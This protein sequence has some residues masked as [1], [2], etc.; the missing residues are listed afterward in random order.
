M[1]QEKGLTIAALI[2]QLHALADPLVAQQQRRFFK[3]GAGQYGEGDRFIGLR[4][5]VLRQLAKQYSG[6]G[7]EDT[8]KLLQSPIHEQRLLA[9]LLLIR[10]YQTGDEGG[11][12]K[13]YTA[14]LK[15]TRF[16][17]N[18]DLVDVSADK[19]VGDWLYQHP[20]DK[21]ILQ[22]LVKSRD[23]WRRRI[24]ML[25]TF[26][27]IRRHDFRPSLALARVLRDDKH[28]LIHKAVGWMLREIGKRD[29]EVEIG[30][31]DRHAPSMPRTMLRY[32]IEK[33]PP[34]LRAHYLNL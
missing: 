21:P 10:L 17:N 28:D 5:P 25:A 6:L 26:Y 32:A 18:W 4:V 27:F 7:L 24:G 33:F 20:K 3:T 23:L 8:L 11:Q 31:L 2:K 15:N 14:Y 9:L 22:Q 13:I 30:F 16:I 1:T 19:I 29:R 12:K 34:R